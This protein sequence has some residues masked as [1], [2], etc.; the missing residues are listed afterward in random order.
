MTTPSELDPKPAT[1][2]TRLANAQVLRDLPFDD[3]FDFELISRG[4]VAPLID[5]GLVKGDK[6]QF[7]F[8]YDAYGFADGEAP[9][10]VNPSLWRQATLMGKGGGLFKLADRL[11]QVIGQDLSNTTI[12]EGDTGLIIG[13]TLM[14]AETAA[15]ALEL[16]YQHRPKVPVKA[17]IFTHSHGDHFGGV[18][19]FVTDE[20][21]ESGA[22][23]VYAPDSFTEEA[24][25]ENVLAGTAMTRRGMY[26]YGSFLRP[27]PQGQVSGGL[28]LSTSHGTSTFAVPTDVITEPVHEEVIDGVRVTFMLAPGTEAPSEMLFYLPDFKAL[29]SAEDVT[30]TMHNLY[31]LRG[32][33][34]RD[35]KAWSHY[36][37]LAMEL[38]PD[39]EIIFAQHHWPTWGNDKILKLMSDQADLYKYLHDQTLRLANKGLTPVEIADQIEV[40]DA[41][42]KQWY[43]RGYYG[44]LSHNVK[45]IY[46]FYLG[47]F[48]GV[49]AHLNP[50]PPV[51]NGKR[52]VEA[53][54]GPDA[55]LTKGKQAFDDGDYRWAAELVNH[56]VFADPSNQ[57]ARELLADTYEQL[58]YQAENGTW[59]NLT[60]GR[61][62]GIAASAGTDAVQQPNRPGRCRR[63]ASRADAGLLGSSPRRSQSCRRRPVVA[64]RVVGHCGQRPGHSAQRRAELRHGQGRCFGRPD[65]DLDP[66]RVQRGVSGNDL[67]HRIHQGRNGKSCGRSV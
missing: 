57:K 51:E 48:D 47:W 60:P 59:R 37:R 40:P 39:V 52:Y 54:G 13:D 15:L 67:A 16:Y 53:V 8:S 62:D 7:I 33:K 56:L 2:A 46:T 5:G 19:G 26:M 30:H 63:D 36:V 1:E 61:S 3:T 34:T 49:P 20:E 28:G 35:A 23:K 18:K 55:L 27:G 14:S 11:Y 43:N 50:H 12:I 38:F 17:I 65:S 4:L 6:G 66:C 24:I 22:V 29:G 44:S 21:I 31:T 58:G 9:D 32:A 64:I 42:G 45:A 10:T 41:I 25:S